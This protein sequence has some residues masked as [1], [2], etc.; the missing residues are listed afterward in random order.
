MKAEVSFPLPTDK[1]SNFSLILSNKPV[2]KWGI[3][4]AGTV[5]VS[6]KSGEER[7]IYLPGTRTYD[8]A[9]ITGKP[10]SH[11]RVCIYV[12]VCMC[13]GDPHAS[14]RI[15]PSCSRTQLAISVTHL[16]AAISGANTE[17]I[18]LIQVYIYS[19]HNMYDLEHVIMVNL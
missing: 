4:F 18:A 16:I 14:E 1:D 11:I 7:V 15:G 8:P 10:Q 6:H 19:Q 17:H 9:G 2:E 3:N 12:Y 5:H 13:I